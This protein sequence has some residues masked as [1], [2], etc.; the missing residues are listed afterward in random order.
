MAKPNN[1]YCRRRTRSGE[2]RYGY[3]YLIGSRGYQFITADL[4]LSRGLQNARG[5]IRLFCWS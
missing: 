4:P 1:C 2:E 5:E 3:L